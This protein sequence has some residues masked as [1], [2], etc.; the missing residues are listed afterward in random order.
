MSIKK[1]FR[2]ERRST[3]ELDGHR[4]EPPSAV[5]GFHDDAS[6]I[7][8]LDERE[9]RLRRQDLQVIDW[10]V[11]A[12]LIVVGVVFLVTAYGCAVIWIQNHLR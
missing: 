4:E 6:G 11:N 5:P 12:A 1:L 2:R 3:A 9:E 7:A 8:D 10:L